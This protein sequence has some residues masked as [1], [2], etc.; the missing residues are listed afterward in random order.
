MF[1]T[2]ERSSLCASC[3]RPLIS[4]AWYL[5][6][7]LA[8]ALPALLYFCMHSLHWKSAYFVGCRTLSTLYDGSTSLGSS[9]TFRRSTRGMNECRLSTASSCS[10][11]CA[12]A[13]WS[14]AL[15]VAAMVAR[16]VSSNSSVRGGRIAMSCQLYCVSAAGGCDGTVARCLPTI[17]SPSLVAPARVRC[18]E[19][20]SRSLCR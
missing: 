3:G 13:R 7:W 6:Q 10:R 17:F 14:K 11:F 16:G 12:C 1:G 15:C 20:G 8:T 4:F 9:R 5:F 2:F 19:H 18:T